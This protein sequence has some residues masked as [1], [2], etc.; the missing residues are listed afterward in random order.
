MAVIGGKPKGFAVIKYCVLC[1]GIMEK[2]ASTFTNVD[3][4]APKGLGRKTLQSL[5]LLS[6]YVQF[7]DNSRV[8]YPLIIFTFEAINFCAERE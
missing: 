5:R 2:D 1:A 3:G 7:W 8:E 4:R 6:A